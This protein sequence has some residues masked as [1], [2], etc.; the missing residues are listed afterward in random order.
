[1]PHFDLFVQSSNTEG[2]PNVL[3]EA[4]AAGVPVV[5]TNVGGTGEVVADGTTG[6]LVPPG[7]ATTLKEAIRQL[8]EDPSQMYE[9]KTAA[10]LYVAQRFN[11]R[12]QA[13]EYRSLFRVVQ[14]RKAQS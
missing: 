9:M 1:M 6:M 3:L 2:L 7:D 5:A 10:P 14:R 13:S 11:F 8:L 12:V 4:A